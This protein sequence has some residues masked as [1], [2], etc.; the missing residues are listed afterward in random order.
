M[1]NPQR[2][3]LVMAREAL[4]QAVEY[5]RVCAVGEGMPGDGYPSR[6]TATEYGNPTIV[7]DVKTALRALAA[8]DA[9]LSPSVER[10]EEAELLRLL[11]IKTEPRRL[12]RLNIVEDCRDVYRGRNTCF[13]Y[14]T[15]SGDL[16]SY[17][18]FSGSVVQALVRAGKLVPTYP[19]QPAIESYR[20]PIF[21]R[22]TPTQ[23]GGDG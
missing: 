1:P 5:A 7:F 15:Y 8:I 16:P 10:D 17:D 13:F 21:R 6:L 3:A 23:D 18:A 12:K 2:E 22:P 14:I 20:L 19:E 11:A 4:K 9:A